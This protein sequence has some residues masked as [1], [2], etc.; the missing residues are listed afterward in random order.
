MGTSFQAYH[1]RKAFRRPCCPLSDGAT[2]KLRIT[3]TRPPIHSTDNTPH[4]T[5]LQPTHSSSA[6][7]STTLYL[8]NPR[9]TPLPACPP[10]HPSPAHAVPSP[11][12]SP[13]PSPPESGPPSGSSQKTHSPGRQTGKST[14]WNPGMAI[15]ITIVVCI[16]GIMMPGIGTSIG[17]SRVG[18]RALGRLEGCCSPSRGT[19]VQRRARANS[20]GALTGN[21]LCALPNP[22]VPDQ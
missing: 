4:P 22:P 9:H 17:S 18:R 20:Y 7:L 15:R 5:G 11:H 3:S 10:I 2:M 1:V 12:A 16:G 6:P 21:P 19:R 13:H 8:T 14:S